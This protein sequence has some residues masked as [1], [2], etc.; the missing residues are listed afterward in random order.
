VT[1]ARPEVQAGFE[2][3]PRR[4][5]GEAIARTRHG[6]ILDA[7]ATRVRESGSLGS[8]CTLAGSATKRPRR[9]RGARPGEANLPRG[10]GLA[11]LNLLRERPASSLPLGRR[12]RAGHRHAQG[13]G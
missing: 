8:V 7:K 9:K 4:S 5:F 2:G 10:L 3:V 11:T 12:Y 1:K 6:V 13:P